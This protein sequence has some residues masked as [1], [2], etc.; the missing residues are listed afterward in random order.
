M[1][2]GRRLLKS[3][4]A[5]RLPVALR[6]SGTRLPRRFSDAGLEDAPVEEVREHVLRANHVVA[7]LAAGQGS[8]SP[9]LDKL[10]GIMVEKR[11]RPSLFV[12][13]E[14]IFGAAR[15]ALV[16]DS[17]VHNVL[18]DAERF[19]ANDGVRALQNDDASTDLKLVLRE[20]R[21]AI[22]SEQKLGNSPPSEFVSQASAI[23]AKMLVET[24][25]VI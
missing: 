2:L 7:S 23:I 11:M 20:R 24:S 9:Y 10:E 12:L 13:F 4:A 1:L 5:T 16:S 15:P 25:K 19:V 8:P 3:D 22:A 17:T 21:D 14:P 18:R 6:G